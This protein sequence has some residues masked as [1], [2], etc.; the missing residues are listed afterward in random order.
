MRSWFMFFILFYYWFISSS[1]E[2]SQRVLFGSFSE[3]VTSILVYM[4]R[5]KQGF[6]VFLESY[7]GNLRG[8]APQCHP[9]GNKPFLKGH[10]IVP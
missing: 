7:D 9:P 8:P 3:E 5:N 1:F 2:V 6:G 4:I 10:I